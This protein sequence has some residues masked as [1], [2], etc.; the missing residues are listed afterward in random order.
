MNPKARPSIGLRY[1]RPELRRDGGPKQSEA[2]QCFNL[3]VLYFDSFESLTS[4]FT[5]PQV[6][7][8]SLGKEIEACDVTAGI[9]AIKPGGTMLQR[10][11]ALWTFGWSMV[12]C[13]VM[14]D[15][16]WLPRI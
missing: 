6:A 11:Q 7:P 15:V 2:F 1:G 10:R 13:T 5:D 16:R 3:V 4:I 8:P 14:I 9:S 12:K